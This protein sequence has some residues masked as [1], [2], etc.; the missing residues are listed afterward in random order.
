M[1]QVSDIIRSCTDDRGEGGLYFRTKISPERIRIGVCID[2]LVGCC[3]Q[4]QLDSQ[5]PFKNLVDPGH[6][7][8]D[9]GQG[10]GYGTSV[11]LG[12][13][14]CCGHCEPVGPQL[15]VVKKFRRGGSRYRLG[16]K[17]FGFTHPALSYGL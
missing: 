7:S 10:I 12:I 8:I 11:V 6:G 5:V 1:E 14:P 17:C 3:N 13:L 9:R 15:L 4:F 2:D 16:C